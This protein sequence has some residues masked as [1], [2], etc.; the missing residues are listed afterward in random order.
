MIN[1][2]KLIYKYKNLNRRVQY[3]LFIFVGFN[4]PENIKK[5]LLKIKELNFYDS[6]M[7]LEKKEL[8]NLIKYY[9]V[10]WYKKLFITDHLNQTIIII[11]KND[12]MKKDLKNVMGD[13]WINDFLNKEITKDKIM[14]NYQYLYNK[15]EKEKN[16]KLQKNKIQTGG[17][18]ENEPY[19]DEALTDYSII[20]DNI[21]FDD[22]DE[23]DIEELEN[24]YRV[25]DIDKNIEETTK[26][27]NSVVD[28]VKKDNKQISFPNDKDNLMYDD[29]LNN[30]FVK[31]YVFNQ[32]IFEDDSIKKIKDKICVSI[33]LNDIFS[34][35]GKTSHNSHLT[36]NSI[37]LWS[38]YSYIN[39]IDKKLK[40][41]K[42]MIGQ[43][44]I[45]KNN[46]L[47]VDIEPNENLKIYEDLRGDLLFLKQDFK[48]SGSRIRRE[49][50][51]FNLLEDY[52]KYIENNEIYIIDIFNDLG[53]NYEVNEKKIRNL[54][55]IYIRIYYSHMSSESFKQILNYLNLENDS[56]R[57]DEINN[58]N[59]IFNTINNDLIV[60]NEIIKTLES[61]DISKSNIFKKN[62]ITHTV[63]HS[64]IV[65]TNIFNFDYSG[66]SK[67]F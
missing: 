10:E 60:E 50:D 44:W 21:T 20:D 46:L 26:L 16:K 1:P 52:Q 11:E 55:D 22:D 13:K 15:Q 7:K 63:I 56:L 40:T 2:I 41:D 35:S 12:K 43:K 34:K 14:Y 3:Q 36:P 5:I 49:E 67:K 65:H 27:I 57:K 9:G 51:E 25:D 28:N 39:H 48:K 45:K 61:V 18:D 33:K 31:N 19:D 58:M 62:H 59:S 37:Y 38:K 24:S 29:S 30:L 4:I 53:L 64:Y 54:Y 47:N 23:F 17:N 6:L 66:L 32:Y 42:I 8:D